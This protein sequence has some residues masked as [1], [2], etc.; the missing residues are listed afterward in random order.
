[1][2]LYNVLQVAKNAEPEVIAAAFRALAK[3]YHPDVC[4]T[5]NA[6]ERMKEINEAYSVLGN[7]TRKEEYDR[8]LISSA[9]FYHSDFGKND[10]TE[11]SKSSKTGTHRHRSHVKAD[12]SGED[13][14]NPDS[15]FRNHTSKHSFEGISGLF[16]YS[17][18]QTTIYFRFHKDGLVLMKNSPPSTRDSTTPPKIL[19]LRGDTYDNSAS[20]FLSCGQIEFTTYSDGGLADFK[21][22]IKGREIHLTKSIWKTHNNETLILKLVQ[23]F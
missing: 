10:F 3:K 2:D 8:T 4:V 1:M 15:I 7:K 11:S 12:F 13:L 17:N 20:Y 16:K 21:G 23:S 9:D 6:D 5:E 22:K 19:R 14:R 18:E